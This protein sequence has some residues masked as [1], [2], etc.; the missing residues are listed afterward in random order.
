MQQ[1]FQ[2][3]L[4]KYFGI[5]LSSCSGVAS[6]TQWHC[7]YDCEN[8]SGAMF[9]ALIVSG[10]Y[11]I[12]VSCLF[13]SSQ[14]FP[15]IVTGSVITTIGFDLIPVSTNINNVDKTNWSALFLPITVL[16]ILVHYF[17]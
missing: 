16:I 15:S 8:G 11:V 2:L 10:I 5:G 17:R 6:P 9:G 1:P 4:T 3:Q 12:L 13:K 7:H 14:F